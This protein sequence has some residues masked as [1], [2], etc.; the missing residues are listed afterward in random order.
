MKLFRLFLL[1]SFCLT[2][3]SFAQNKNI[4]LK[5][6][7]FQFRDFQLKKTIKESNYIKLGNFLLE[8]SPK[9][10]LLTDKELIRYSNGS[11]G[12]KKLIVDLNKARIKLD[13]LN[14]SEQSV[15]IDSFHRDL[16]KRLFSLESKR[17]WANFYLSHAFGHES[18][19]ALTRDG[20]I[21]P[22]FKSGSFNN[23]NVGMLVK[24]R[25]FPWGQIFLDTDLQIKNYSET[26]LQDRNRI[27]FNAELGTQF[28]FNHRTL[29]ISIDNQLN[30]FEQNSSSRKGLFDFIPQ[31][32]L[33]SMHNKP[34][35]N[36]F[37]LSE[38]EVFFIASFKDYSDIFLYD[39]VGNNKDSDSI[40]LGYRMDWINE[41]KFYT[42]FFN[43]IVS[44]KSS[45]S[46]AEINNYSL[47]ELNLEYQIH[48]KERPYRFVSSLDVQKYS[49]LSYLGID[50]N[51]FNT[52]LSFELQRVMFNKDSE[53]FLKIGQESNS[54]DHVRFEYDNTEILAGLKYKW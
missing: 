16:A 6:L 8:K 23:T 36:R 7:Y 20:N 34:K 15:L 31:I 27:S 33:V 5:D 1:F 17:D 18:E 51:D 22:S 14:E 10:G 19:S 9:D 2:G 45:D 32:H 53:I 21:D 26:S 48:M 44:Y 3:G 54:S 41:R 49:G 38:T 25:Y 11:V 43:G 52:K 47:I 50:R 40:K 37:V 35:A 29:S 24:G 30:F 42:H 39:V 13:S 28:K 12:I 4:I 46:S